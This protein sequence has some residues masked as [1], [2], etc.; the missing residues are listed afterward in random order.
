MKDVEF[1][2]KFA[3]SELGLIRRALKAYDEQLAARQAMYLSEDPRWGVV[4][5]RRRR[6]MRLLDRISPVLD[7]G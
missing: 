7:E 3:L 1:T 4:T 5:D 6:L 2:I